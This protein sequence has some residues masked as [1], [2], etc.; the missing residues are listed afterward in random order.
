MPAPN[1]LAPVKGAGTT[2]WIYTG[3]GDAFANPTTDVDW[4]RLAKIKDLQPGELTAESYDDT[5]LDDENADWADT[6]QGAKSA[7]D[8]TIT[9]AW[10]PG[11]S[12]QQDLVAWFES[13]DKR[14]YKIKYPNGTIDVYKGWISSLGKTIPAKEI[15]TRSVKVTNTGKPSL[16]EDN[17]APV[18]AVTGVTL[19]KATLS[20]KAGAND[21]VNVTINPAGASDKTFR[22]SSSDPTK[23]TVAVNGDV[24]TI[25]G[26]AAGSAEIVV[27]TNDGLFVGICAATV[28]A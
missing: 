16:A 12:G 17:R 1:P 9:L 11:E 10:K 26:K 28:T 14:V 6:A 7:G 4:T 22:A 25:T 20:I 19:D 8:A 13:G 27:M 5:Y 2:L 3:S 15:I 21:T 18:T 24:L 23:A